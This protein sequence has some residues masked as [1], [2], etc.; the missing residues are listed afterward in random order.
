MGCGGSGLVCCG[1][2]LCGGTAVVGGAAWGDVL[3]SAAGTLASVTG[4]TNASAPLHWLSPH[5]SWWRRQR[6]AWTASAY[7]LIPPCAE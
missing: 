3:A 2:K 4:R 1:L 5:G 7:G 6:S